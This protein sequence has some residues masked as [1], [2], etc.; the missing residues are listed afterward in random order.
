MNCVKTHE[1]VAKLHP[2]NRVQRSDSIP[3]KLDL[4]PT[5]SCLEIR[6]TVT[7]RYRFALKLN[8]RTGLVV[9]K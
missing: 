6:V 9:R 8:T 1:T 2:K 4:R 7:T 5:R 3:D